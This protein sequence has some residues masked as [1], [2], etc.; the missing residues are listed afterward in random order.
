M[1][2]VKKKKYYFDQSDRIRFDKFLKSN[3]LKR[4]EFAEKC[5]ISP[6]LLTMIYQGKR[7]ITIDVA[8]NFTKN[9]FKIKLGE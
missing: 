5:F 7:A 9:G 8:D 1:I 3:G 6:T 2:L 4:C